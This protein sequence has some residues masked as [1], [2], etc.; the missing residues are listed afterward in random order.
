MPSQKQI[1]ASRANGARSHGPVTTE[2]KR[3]SSQNARKHGLLAQQIV[4]GEESHDDFENAM[5]EHIRILKPANSVE[6]TIVENIVSAF[7]RTRR[8]W[9]IEARLMEQR[10]KDQRA[11]DDVDCLA[12]AFAALSASG[13][14][15]LL[16]RY[17]ARLHRMYRRS[18]QNLQLLREIDCPNEPGETEEPDLPN[19]PGETEEPDLPNEPD[20]PAE[21]ITED[22]ETVTL[23]TGRSES[24]LPPRRAGAGWPAQPGAGDPRAPGSAQT[25]HPLD[26][27]GNPR[28][29][30]ND[31][32]EP[33]N[34]V[35]APLC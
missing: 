11:G 33:T 3:R 2:G 30:S 23:Q 12:G 6:L 35:H 19:E 27:A 18:I 25:L 1:E 20:A 34:S 29:Q 17:E 16:E 4:V 22:P 31:G 21:P 8:L 26:L 28:S 13:E 7:W 14:L 5:E 9:A 24:T 10:I 15:S 32:C